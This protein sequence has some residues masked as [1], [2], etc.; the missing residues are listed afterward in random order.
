MALYTIRVVG[1]VDPEWSDWFEGLTITNTASG[2]TVIS[3][4]IVDQAAL[5][6][7]LN[8]V[9][10]LNLTLI[11]VTSLESRTGQP[12]TSQH[13]SNKTNL[14]PERRPTSETAP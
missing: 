3:G 7:T 14:M 1:P 6:G 12:Q 10:N 5:H 9:R 2:V 4:E 8:K 13:Q 11:S